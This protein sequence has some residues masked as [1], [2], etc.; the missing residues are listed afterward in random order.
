MKPLKCFELFW[1]EAFWNL[2]VVETNRKAAAVEAAKHNNYV[3]KPFKKLTLPALKAFIGIR[4]FTEMIVHK[5]MCEAY[6]H[7]EQ[8][9]R[10]TCTPGVGKIVSRDHF[11]AIWS[12]LHFV[13]ESDPNLAKMIKSTK[14]DQFVF[15]C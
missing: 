6:F 4:I 7:S 14:T 10:I 3:V 5:D 12:M 15:T 8:H 2:I 9:H 11:F 1:I 13:N